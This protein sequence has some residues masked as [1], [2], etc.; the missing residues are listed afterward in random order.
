[1][2][3]NNESLKKLE[4]RNILDLSIDMENTID[5]I[6]K[7]WEYDIISNKSINV[8]MVSFLYSLL[9]RNAIVVIPKYK[10]STVAQNLNEKIHIIPENRH[11]RLV[12]IQ[13]NSKTFSFTI[14]IIDMNVINGDKIGELRCFRLTDP[15]GNW[16]KGIDKLQVVSPNKNK[17]TEDITYNN[18]IKFDYFIDPKRWTQ[19]YSEKYFITK[20]LINRLKVESSHYYSCIKKMLDDGIK[21]PSEKQSTW[22]STEQKGEKKLIKLFMSEVFHSDYNNEFPV[23][24]S[25]QN[26]L[27]DLTNRRNKFIYSIIPKLNFIIRAI[28]YSF[29]KVNNNNNNIIPDEIKEKFGDIKWENIKIKRTEWD[30]LNLGDLG[31]R[32][33]VYEKNEIM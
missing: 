20:S 1:M 22:A 29:F 25:N 2:I 27:V 10:A 11:G 24:T 18:D 32:K 7:K 3:L 17:L 30:V 19:F 5:I 15:E 12:G 8:D 16:Y 26:N 21:Y 23:L 9:N 13:G 14:K 33:R 4:M 6:S 28:E 31:I